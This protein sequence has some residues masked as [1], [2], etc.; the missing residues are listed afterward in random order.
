MLPRKLPQA[1]A[2]GTQNER[3]RTRERSGFEPL[4]RVFGETY[5][6]NAALA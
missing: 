3:K 1:F 6:E 4:A 2:L 5:A